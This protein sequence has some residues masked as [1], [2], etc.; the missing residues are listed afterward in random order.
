M[1]WFV[2]AVSPRSSR[3][4]RLILAVVPVAFLGVFF[5]WPTWT[6]VRTGLAADGVWGFGVVA[7]VVADP[8]LRRV[9]WFTLWQAVV[10]TIACMALGLPAAWV[11]ARFR[12]RGRDLA[13]AALLV[14]FVLPTVVVGAA[15]LAL[16][17]PDG[18]GGLGPDLRATWVAVVI[19]HVYFNLA[20]VIRVVGGFWSQLDP[21]LGDAARLLGASRWRAWREVTLPLLWPSIGSA[22][23]IVFLFC[24]TSFGAVVILGGV[25]QRT[26][27][28]E[29]FSQVRGLH[30]DVAAVLA[31]AQ[32]VAVVVLLALWRRVQ[33]RT[34]GAVTLLDPARTGRSPRGW[35]ERVLVAAVGVVL[36]VFLGAPLTVLAWRSVATPDGLGLDFYRALGS[37]GRGATSFVPPVEAV[38]NSLAFAAVAAALATTIGGLAALAVARR[39][40][41]HAGPVTDRFVQRWLD[42]AL[43]LPLGTSAVTVGL[44]LF[45]AL[46]R[47]PIDLRS[48]PLLVPIAHALVATPFVVRALVPVL[49]RLDPRPREAA[50]LLGA[51]PWQAWRVADSPAVLRGFVVAAGFAFA[52]SLG[53]FGATVF[54]ARADWPTMPIVIERAL[55]RPGTLNTGQA[56]A[57]ATVLMVLTT[58]VIVV[59]ERLRPSRGALL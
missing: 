33:V 51:S 19:A 58:A 52:V 4:S 11:F 38:R 43:L 1:P 55:G 15:W 8:S 56:M 21:R 17:G 53:E 13:W 2:E 18:L 54:L 25:R 16:L 31:V 20:V 40:G 26:I 30:L 57:L 28:V 9:A 6:I 59:L 23:S 46:D 45:L 42:T 49:E 5:V 24:F 3:T 34:S 12:F 48:S 14:P 32:I 29:I 41:A 27:E 36:V 22:A 50:R 44:G 10:S 7:D 47:P 35:P 39:P 37:A